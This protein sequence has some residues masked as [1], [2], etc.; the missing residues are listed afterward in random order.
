MPKPTF[1]QL[2]ASPHPAL[3]ELLHAIAAAI[4][5]AFG[6]APA[7]TE[8]IE[9]ADARI[10]MLA[11]R[12]REAATLR[13][14]LQM[15]A[16]LAALAPQLRPLGL[17]ADEADLA[18]VRP[19]LVTVRGEG[20]PMLLAAVGAAVAQ[21]AGLPIGVAASPSHVLLAHLESAETRAM[22]LRRQRLVT[23]SALRDPGLTWHCAH[24]L[25]AL[26]LD[27]IA[28]RAADYGLRPVQVAARELAMHLPLDDRALLRRKVELQ[29]ARANWN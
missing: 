12:L 19:D 15:E 10:S 6:A 1:E 28:G 9:L 17:H 23:P 7:T 18:A 3:D 14:H 22:D 8:R 13:P 2:I 27:L 11:G 26:V 16:L 25:A 5:A 21:R 24:E 4:G 29:R 20:H